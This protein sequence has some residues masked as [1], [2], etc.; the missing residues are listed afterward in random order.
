MKELLLKLKRQGIEIRVIN[1]E[2]RLSNIYEGFEGS[3]LMHEVRS[4]KK[5]IINYF[6]SRRIIPNEVKNILS[7]SEQEYY[8][9]SPQQRRFFFLH[10]LAPSSLAYNMSQAYLLEGNLDI[11]KVEQMFN[12]VIERHETLRTSFEIVDKKV[13]QK[14]AAKCLLIL[15]HT[16]ATCEEE[17]ST[18]VSQ[19]VKPFDLSRAPLLRAEVIVL[20]EN[21][22]ILL[23]DTHHIISDGISQQILLKEF[24]AAYNGQPLPELNLQYKDYSEWFYNSYEEHARLQKD[25]WNKEFSSMPKP[26]QLPLDFDRPEVK[27]SAGSSFSFSVDQNVKDRLESLAISSQSSLFSI[28]IS[29]LGILLSKLGNQEDIIIGTPTAGRTHQDLN[30]IIGIFVNTL[31]IRLFTQY[32]LTFHS[33]LQQTTLKILDCFDHQDYSYDQLVDDLK[34]DRSLSHN[35]LFDVLFVLQNV[36]EEVAVFKDLKIHHYPL[37]NS[38]SKFDISLSA[39]ASAIGLDFELEFSTQL[40]QLATIERFSGYY[41]QI[42]NQIAENANILLEDIDIVSHDEKVLSA[43][44][45][46]LFIKVNDTTVVYPEEKTIIDLFVEQA[47][48]TPDNIAVRWENQSL[49]YRDL[50]NKSQ[51]M[52]VYLQQT[53]GVKTGDLVGLLLERE[54][55]MLPSVFGIMNSGAA[56]VPLSIHYPSDRINSILLD[57]KLKVLITRGR[58]INDLLIPEGIEVVDLDTAMIKIA[59][60]IHHQPISGPCGKDLAYVI[61]TSGSTGKPKG[62]MIEH[63][64]VINRILWMQKAYPL[65]PSDVLLQKT[66]I[67]FDVSVWELF[68]WSFTGASVYLLAPGDEKDPQEI[69]KAIEVNKVTTIHFV[70]SMLSAFLSVLDD[71]TYDLSTLRRVF[72][73]GE[74]L[75]PDVVN[76]FAKKLYKDYGCS[77][78]NL[79]G[80]TEAT[81]DVSY[82]ECDFEKD[83]KIIPIG[84]P[85]DN[86]RLYIINKSGRSCPVGE[87]G[88]LYIGGVSLARGYLN[89]EA[90]T[91]KKFVSNLLEPDSRLYCTGDMARWLPDGNI[92]YLGRTDNQVKIRG[93][94][95]ELGEIE[96]N[97]MLYDHIK[98]AVVAVHG[99]A[100]NK[101][102]IAFVV[103]QKKAVFN[104]FEIKNFL[105]S[106]LPDYMIPSIVRKVDEIPLTTNGKADVNSLLKLIDKVPSE[107]TY[108]F[109]S[110]IKLLNEDIIDQIIYVAPETPLQHILAD[111][112]SKELSLVQV[113]LND[114]FFHLGGDSLRAIGLVHE[115]NEK[116]NC[117]LGVADIYRFQ[118]IATLSGI[119]EVGQT[120]FTDTD[121][122]A[123]LQEVLAF[124]EDYKQRV[125][126][127]SA[128]QEVLP[129]NA[130]EKGMVFY[131]LKNGSES[132]NIHEILYHEQNIY[133]ISTTT[134]DFEIFKK[135]INLLVKK[136]DALR[137][138]FDLENFAHIIKKV[139]EPELY[140][141][142]L[143]S[144]DQV[145]QEAVVLKKIEDEKLKATGLDHSVLWR[146]SMLKTG[147]IT[148]LLLFDM[149]HSLL[150]GWS[151]QSFISE[152]NNTYIKLLKNPDYHPKSLRCSYKDQIIYEFSET[153][154]TKNILF[155]QNEMNGAGRLNFPKI[156]TENTFEN[157]FYDLGEGLKS[158]LEDK[159][160]KSGTSLK[161]ICFA[162]YVYSMTLYASDNDIVVGMVTNNRPVVADSEKLLGC[163][164]N[165]VPVRIGI[166]EDLT[167]NDYVNLIEDKLQH[168]KNHERVPLQDIVRLAGEKS[169]DE[170]PFFDT[171]FNYMNF[172]VLKEMVMLEGSEDI[173]L[174]YTDKMRNLSYVNL[175][176]FCAFHVRP[177]PFV[178]EISYATT[179]F[180]ELAVEKLSRKFQHFLEQF[181]K[182]GDK[183]IDDLDTL[184]AQEIELFIK[185][186]DTAVV[187]P[188]EKTIIDLF[189]EQADKTPDNIAVR[190]E[191]Q[192]LTYRDLKNKSQCMAVYLQQ[193]LGVK[194]GDLVGLLLEREEEMLPS[195]FGI[196]NSGAAYVPLSIHYPSDRINSILLDGKLKVLITRGRYIND[197]LIPEGI[198]VVDLDTAMIKI[199]SQIHHQPISG[200]CGKDLAYVIYTSGSTGKP[201]G[202]MIEHHSVI[203]RILWMQKA[204]PLTPS[205]VLLQKTPITFDVSVWELFWWSFTGASVYLLA[206]GDEKDPQEIQKAIEVNKVTTIHFVP[207]MLS[208]FLSVLDDNTYDLST[209]RRVFSSGEALKPDV[210]NQFAK[211]LYKD[212]GCSLVNLYGP[213][214][215]TVDVSYYECDF[216]KDSKIIPI[217][218]PIDNTRL[219]IIN[220]SGRSCPV[221]ESGELYIGG[222][223]LARGYLNDEAL[224]AKKFVSNLLEPDSRLYCTGDMARWLPDGNIEYL[225]RT[226]NQVKI[227]GFRIELGE[228]ESNLMLYDHIKQ[229]VVAVHGDAD[230]KKIIAFVVPQ[231]KAVFSLFE[232][233]NFLRSKLPDYMIPS[234]VRKVDEIPLTTNGKADVNSLLKLIDKI[235][236]EETFGVKPKTDIE[237]YIA[238]TWCDLLN[239][240]AV[241]IEDNFLDLGGHSLQLIRI[242]KMIWNQYSVELPLNFYFNHTLGQIAMEI[243]NHDKFSEKLL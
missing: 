159:A 238:R 35:P 85:I 142:D 141:L 48:K 225:G 145:S 203:N 87:S 117:N 226:D 71:N 78:V 118:T 129:M 51:C 193:T 197:L 241:N 123:A 61:Y 200:P 126:W 36:E 11:S 70:P 240:N 212:Y 151:L 166:S 179:Y 69:Q 27:N 174:P 229:A 230:D 161:H 92:E 96:S 201:K 124:E 63:H 41:K 66:P 138:V 107:E 109:E 72:S 2:L 127:T 157:I 47:D 219:Y 89:D 135:A 167:I 143:S 227:R 68:W 221:G 65:T 28:L 42:L 34:I 82:Y 93:F 121:Y 20:D 205:D 108:G 91:A 177:D 102:I 3:D 214:E 83:S 17:I 16:F 112:W 231:K 188:E 184:S 134:F 211:K 158:A 106:K 236:S 163:Y 183:R 84:K 39:V 4:Q 228:I 170:N 120:A 23:L 217:G 46:E 233:K 12:K 235:P 218:K 9:V 67:T 103:P 38:S 90:L 58:Y 44:E 77:L 14:V 186:N 180:D 130:I 146:M 73:S 62:V 55:E 131:S 114:N 104:L 125:G 189:V 196:M 206:P 15:K 22:H 148:Y 57:G 149:H 29:A 209:L 53:L 30:K 43:Q 191:N 116:L 222:V 187:Y 164:L 243:A 136:H 95:I 198:E 192:S 111:I 101:K 50:K 160:K 33:Y 19:F 26:L 178:L 181:L 64:S 199:A 76:Q 139:I 172:W 49:T 97:L 182:N 54:E 88:E 169:H 80:P 60:Q 59:S 1:D 215:A 99:D 45:I 79:Y 171:I 152:L 113:G 128:Y 204:Y 8:R 119:I 140:Y 6:N 94:R 18:I 24:E 155:W 75:K 239:V 13:V 105:R 132:A 165:S 162:A 100:D 86:T 147:P 153:R 185:V 175:N 98:Q 220:K 216:E 137:K 208:A 74:A 234:I 232:I 224:T 25:F 56:Y 133:R 176:T 122:N 173:N 81:V 150:D 31:P 195:V 213:T 21:R 115:M 242:N 156:S 207:S 7:V 32:H 237:K 144:L 168:L 40:F 5:D 202:V 190:W 210:V 110:E 10:K 223:S 52:A 194:T 154:R 37:N